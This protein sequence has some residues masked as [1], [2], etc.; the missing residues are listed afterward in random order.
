MLFY[1]YC[2]LNTR[3]RLSHKTAI[4]HW[5]KERYTKKCFLRIAQNQAAPNLSA[6]MRFSTRIN[7]NLSIWQRSIN[8]KVL[9]LGA[10]LFLVPS[11]TSRLRL[12]RNKKK[13]IGKFKTQEYSWATFI[14]RILRKAQ[15]QQIE[16]SQ[17]GI[18]KQKKH[19]GEIRNAFL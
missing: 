15:W 5:N 3:T 10:F 7:F 9:R 16:S 8:K 17:T 2:I 11:R 18:Q 13:A 12:S 6:Y 1:V 4:P 14:N 19:S